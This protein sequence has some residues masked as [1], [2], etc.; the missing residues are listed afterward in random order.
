MPQPA[1]PSFMED[2]SLIAARA[3]SIAGAAV[4]YRADPA[5]GAQT[6]ADPRVDDAGTGVRGHAGIGRRIDS[7][8]HRGYDRDGRHRDRIRSRRRYGYRRRGWRW[9]IDYRSRHRIRGR[10]WCRN[11]RWRWCWSRCG[12]WFRSRCWRGCWRWLYSRR[13]FGRRLTGIRRLTCC[14]R[15][16]GGTRC[17]RRDGRLTG[18][19]LC[20]TWLISTSRLGRSRRGGLTAGRC[21]TI[22][23]RTTW[24]RTTRCCTIRRGT[25]RCRTISPRATRCRTISRRTARCCTAGCRCVPCR[26]VWRCRVRSCRAGCLGCVRCPGGSGRSGAVRTSGGLGRIRL[27]CRRRSAVGWRAGARRLIGV[28]LGGCRRLPSAR[29]R[30]GIRLVSTGYRRRTRLITSRCRRFTRLISAR[31]RRCARLV[32][33][34]R[35]ILT[36]R[37]I[38]AC[39]LIGAGWF[40][41][42]LGLIT[43]AIG[44]RRRRRP[45]LRRWILEGQH[46]VVGIRAQRRRGRRLHLHRQ[47][48]PQVPLVGERRGDGSDIV[49]SLD[50]HLG[51]LVVH[52]LLEIGLHHTAQQHLPEIVRVVRAVGVRQVNA[53]QAFLTGEQLVTL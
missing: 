28:R 29:R 14:G 31:R 24:C 41:G 33:A 26:G 43:G 48:H 21:R 7:R 1:T 15:R 50:A 12:R 11:W 53:V 27:G 32:S 47:L 13:G 51:Q 16:T 49:R 17:V 25:T 34:C 4:G 23:C 30:A 45:W 10:R 19:R 44:V 22:R 40:A 5:V 35:L 6:R 3:T 18:V 9:N 36:C 38:R 8:V 2:Y 52:R 20:R 39:R 42:V 46:R 37:L